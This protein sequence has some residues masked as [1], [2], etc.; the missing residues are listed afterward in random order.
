MIASSSL[1]LLLLAGVAS[2][3]HPQHEAYHAELKRQAAAAPTSIASTTAPAAA[4]TGSLTGPTSGGFFQTTPEPQPSGMGTI[5]ALNEI[6]V[7][8]PVFISGAKACFVAFSLGPLP[9]RASWYQSSPQ[10]F[11]FAGV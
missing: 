11:P 2:A 7:R 10:L 5:P 6:T 3:V 1:S 4:A 9:A 8:L